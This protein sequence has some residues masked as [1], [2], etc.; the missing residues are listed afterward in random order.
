MHSSFCL[1]WKIQ[2]TAL[3]WL[4]GD[5][6]HCIIAC[7]NH[8]P[9]LITCA[10]TLQIPYIH[11]YS[12]LSDQFLVCCLQVHRPAQK[13][14][15][16]TYKQSGT[17]SRRLR[18]KLIMMVWLRNV[19]PVSLCNQYCKISDCM[20][21]QVYPPP[22]TLS[23][24]IIL[25]V[26]QAEPFHLLCPEIHKGARMLSLTTSQ[27]MLIRRG[28][29]STDQVILCRVLW[30]FCWDVRSGQEVA[31]LQW[32]T[33]STAGELL[34]SWQFK[35]TA[36]IIHS[37]LYTCVFICTHTASLRLSDTVLHNGFPSEAL[38]WYCTHYH[39]QWAWWDTIAGGG[40]GVCGGNWERGHL[41]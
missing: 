10:Y 33:D 32:H 17:K 39:E 34:L 4:F 5:R 15:Q 24:Q 18:L 21:T 11:I 8:M 31:D 14:L 2:R 23:P 13:G 16:D 35:C 28:D 41:L 36:V 27:R 19:Y 6:D 7:R 9:Y 30:P 37:L 3:T 20:W 38:P 25:Y 40:T 12:Q 22:S 26:Y 29:S 1:V